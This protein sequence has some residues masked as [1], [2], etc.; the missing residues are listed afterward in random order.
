MTQANTEQHDHTGSCLCGRVRVTTHGAL[1][2]VIFCHCTQCRKQTGLF[3]AATDIEDDA[4]QVEGVENVAWFEASDTAKRGFCKNCGSALFWKS[5]GSTRTSVMAGLFDKPSSLQGAV[6][7][8]TAD[9]GDFYE[10]NDD[11][12]RHEGSSSVAPA[13][14][15]EP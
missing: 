11:L 1:R 10:I 2:G 4:L 5:K 15:L 6:H 13:E 8:F 7:I 14:T 3:Y 12:P 9:K